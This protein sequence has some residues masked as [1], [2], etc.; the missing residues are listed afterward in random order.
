MEIK[1]YIQIIRRHLNIFLAVIAIVVAGTFLV[2]ALRPVTYSASLGLN[3]T[4]SG[5]QATPDYKFDDFYRLQADE[6]FAETV[7]Q[8]LKDPRTVADI[9]GAAGLN[10]GE[11]SIRQLAKS[12][13]PE[14]LSS[15]FI[16]V[17]LTARS[18]NSAKKISAA[19]ADAV[20]K[21]TGAL[22]KDQAENAWFEIVA[23]NPVIIRDR[24]SPLIL[25][26]A[27]MAGGIFLAF[28]TILIIHY[29]K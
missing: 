13:V 2:A 14:K 6:K 5:A 8:W 12:F 27:S 10:V 26:L 18:E 22:N 16:S 19:I 9:Y 28:W 15:Q 29:L 17:S 25:F 11:F 7:V 21:N 3:I 20:S 4:R 1:E 24:I 23:Q